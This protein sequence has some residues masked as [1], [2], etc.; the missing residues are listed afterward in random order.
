[1]WDCELLDALSDGCASLMNYL[2]LFLVC[3]LPLLS[4][5]WSRVVENKP[6]EL[7]TP[8]PPPPLSRSRSSGIG[9][10]PT[11]ASMVARMLGLREPPSPS[12]SFAAPSPVKA[13][14]VRTWTT[15]KATVSS[16]L[17]WITPKAKPA[18]SWITPPTRRRKVVMESPV[19]PPVF[20]RRAAPT[21]A[22]VADE[23]VTMT[24][25]LGFEGSNVDVDLVVLMTHIQAACKHIASVLASPSELQATLSGADALYG[26]GRDAPKPLDIVANNIIKSALQSSGKVAAIASEEDDRP[27]WIGEGP[28]VVVFDPLDG[29]RNI[30]ASIPTG[31]IFGV[32]RRLP[33]ADHLPTEEEAFANVMQKGERQVAAGYAL[34]SSATIMAIS[35]GAGLHGFTLD[36]TIGEFVYSHHDLRIPERGQIYSVNDARYFDWPSGLR[37]YIDTV[38]QGKGQ[39]RKQYS[40]RYICSLVADLHR[41]IMYGGI[42]MNPRSHLRLLYEANPLCFLVEQGGGKGT[43]GKRRI[44]EINPIEIH[45]RLPLFLGSVADIDELVSYGDIQQQKNPGY[46][47]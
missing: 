10:K 46:T 37:K 41:T 14:P 45:Q 11:S 35:V 23:A 5:R 40:A 44:L 29:S 4:F 12:P 32:Y 13:K 1:M 19:L 47:V 28:Y 18:L 39:T 33:E 27:I 38:R 17:S 20:V 21:Q 15:P 31:T 25:F 16:A 34:Y 42:A 36:Y 8:P 7:Y 9:N 3:F 43:D 6:A 22:V 30:D 2:L 24:A 26:E